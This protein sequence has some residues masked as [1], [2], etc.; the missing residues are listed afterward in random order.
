MA[1]FTV[2]SSLAGPSVGTILLATGGNA[3]MAARALASRDLIWLVGSSWGAA[4]GW[5]QLLSMF[6]GRTAAG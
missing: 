6:L 2:A 4:F 1:N 5:L 3:L